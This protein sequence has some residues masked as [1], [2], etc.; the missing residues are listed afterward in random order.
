MTAFSSILSKY[1]T[2]I[3]SDHSIEKHANKGVSATAFFDLL[4]VTGLDKNLLA[5][6]VFNL[7]FKTISRYKKENK[8]LNPR[9]SETVLKLVQLFKKGE[10]I[11]GSFITFRSWLR[12]PAH[13]LGKRQPV[14][15]LTTNTGIDLIYEE[16]LR[17]EFGA[18]A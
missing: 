7:S 10:E 2:E 6:D 18:L 12:K 14:R 3:K 4:E 15:M 9:D 1:S 11:F 8:K 5:E 17:I 13:G 16:L